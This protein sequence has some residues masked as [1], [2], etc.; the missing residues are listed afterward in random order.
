MDGVSFTILIGISCLVML[1][2]LSAGSAVLCVGQN[3]GVVLVQKSRLSW[4]RYDR[5]R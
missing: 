1:P 3:D 5:M 4:I 2:G